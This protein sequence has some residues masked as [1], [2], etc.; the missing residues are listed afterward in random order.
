M[1]R[2]E[3]LAYVLQFIEDVLDALES[4][5]ELFKELTC[6]DFSITF[7]GNKLLVPINADTVELLVQFLRD[8]EY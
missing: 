2:E 1:S 8:L 7:K 4:N 5:D 6:D 3:M